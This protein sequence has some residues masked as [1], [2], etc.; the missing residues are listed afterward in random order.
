MPNSDR[1]WENSKSQTDS[2]G[3]SE[4]DL[5][6]S[7]ADALVSDFIISGNFV[8]PALGS[9]AQRCSDDALVELALGGRDVEE[10]AGTLGVPAAELTL[11]LVE[12]RTGP[13]GCIRPA[14]DGPVSGP[15]A[16]VK[17]RSS[18]PHIVAKQRPVLSLVARAVGPRL[19]RLGDRLYL[20]GEETTLPSLVRLARER[21]VRIR[22]PTIDPMDHAWDTGPSRYDSRA[23]AGSG[24]GWLQ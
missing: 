17:R 9:A 23:A 6:P 5:L 1:Y 12:L 10:I 13:L 21:G 8:A 2:E 11:R 16:D 18:G 14:A 22:Y 24:P 20:S 7:T 15:F 3:R 4:G 19:Q